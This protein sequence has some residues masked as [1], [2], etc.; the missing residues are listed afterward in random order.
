MYLVDVNE[1]ID[2]REEFINNIEVAHERSYL[3]GRLELF[4][5]VESDDFEWEENS[6]IN[7]VNV[8]IQD[9]EEYF[10]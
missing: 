5:I 1:Q 2:S 4:D 9:F 10:K 7:K 8:S 3:D 6:D